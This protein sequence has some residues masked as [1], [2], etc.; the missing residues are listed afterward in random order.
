MIEW[1]PTVS[2]NLVKILTDIEHSVWFDKNE[3]VEYT[4]DTAAAL[5]AKK[6]RNR[7]KHIDQQDLLHSEE[8]CSLDESTPM[9]FNYLTVQVRWR[10]YCEVVDSL[11]DFEIV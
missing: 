11:D 8:Y 10:R 9:F 4:A 2:F 1:I 7:I 6:I 5:V 3:E